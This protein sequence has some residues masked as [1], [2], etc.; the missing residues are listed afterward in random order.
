MVRVCKDLFPNDENPEKAGFYMDDRLKLQLDVLLK[1]IKN[2]WDFT[3]IVTGGGEVRV[4]KSMLAMQIGAYWS[5]EIKK[6]YGSTIP[7]NVQENFVFEGENLI[8]QGN[9]LGKKY[10]FSCLIFDEAGADLEGRKTMQA[11]TQAVLDYFRECGQYNMLNILVLPEFFD[12]PKGIA[13]TRS[14]FLINAD[15]YADENSM[16]QRGYFDFFSRRAKKY[17]YLKGKKDLDYKAVKG[18]FGSNKGRFYKFF[19]IDE[20]EYRLAKQEALARRETKKRNKFQVQRDAL[21]YL[22]CSE[23]QD[24]EIAVG[25][26]IMTQEQLAVRME[27]LT[28]IFVARNTLSDAL[29]R[30]KGELNEMEDE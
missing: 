20:G 17:L 6:R 27:Q 22:L 28:G 10:P 29:T 26:K 8:K 2:D 12:L 5:Y 25:Q 23:K 30:L 9:R 19:P 13:I 24:K 11:S 16:F 15:Y 18:E 1:N 14:I 4:G 7:F 21:I 3:I